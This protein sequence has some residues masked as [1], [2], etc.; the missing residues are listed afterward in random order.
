MGARQGKGEIRFPRNDRHLECFARLDDYGEFDAK[1]FSSN[2]RQ[3]PLIRQA[4]QN[5]GLYLLTGSQLQLI[6]RLPLASN[7]GGCGRFFKD[8]RQ[9]LDCINDHD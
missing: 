3:K 9:V 6:G 4:G 5:L 8:L 7:R 1:K 2:P